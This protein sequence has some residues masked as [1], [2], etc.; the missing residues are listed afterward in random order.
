MSLKE[1]IV[2][3]LTRAMKAGEKVRLATLRTVKAALMEREIEARGTGKQ[4]T[5]DDEM[6][7]LRSLAKMRK[8]S[9]GLFRKGNRP[10][11][12]DAEAEELRIIEEYLPKMMSESEIEGALNGL[13]AEI[14]ASS[15]SD[16]P[17][18]MPA[19]MKALKGRAEGSLVQAVARRKLGGE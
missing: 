10:E 19:A 11:L 7:V 13:M 18:L 4:L 3:D 5:A 12:A 15:M 1:T 16:F 9:I 8:E 2:K 14:G 6:S 17:R